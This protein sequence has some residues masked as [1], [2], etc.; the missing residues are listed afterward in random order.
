MPITFSEQKSVPTILYVDCSLHSGIDRRRLDGLRRYAAARKWRVETLE[1][2]DCT[3]AALREA[4]AR[5]RPIGCAAECWCPDTAPRPPLF[6]RTPV[7]Y[8]EPPDGPRW[9]GVHGIM[10]DNAAVGRMAFEELS[11]TRPPAYAV[12]SCV[13]NRRWAR[14]RID[15]FRECSRKA[16]ADCDVAQFP[17]EREDEFEA[18]VGR[19]VPWV[20]ALPHRCA[21]FAVNDLFAIAVAEAM[22]AAGRSFPRSLTLVGADGDD[23]PPWDRELAETIS[24]VRLDF[25]LGGYLAA[26]ALGAFAANEGPR[27]A[28]N[29]GLRFARN[30]GSRKREIKGAAHAANETNSSFAPKAQTSFGG[31]ATL[32][33]GAAAP[34]LVFPPILVERRKSTR[35]YGRREPRILEA[36]EMIRREACDGL[37]AANLAGRFRGT[38]QLFDLRFREAMGHSPLDEIIHVRLQRVLELLAQPDFPISAIADFSGFSS[39]RVLQKH[40]R[41]RFHTSMRDWRKARQ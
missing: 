35:G 38:R 24:T 10:C 41:A 33:C 28:R 2:K 17:F 40:F 27:S 30:E 22:V 36:V 29:E 16:G 5:L 25:E 9:R 19:M 20:A 12:V 4:L 31:N 7:V 8:F 15:A 32:H 14:E 26:K 39:E 6:G 37:T 23:P 11:S 13:Q 1:H 18:C 21:V 34:S 3:P